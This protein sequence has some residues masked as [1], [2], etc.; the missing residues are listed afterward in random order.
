VQPATADY[1]PPVYRRRP[2]HVL[3]TLPAIIND[4]H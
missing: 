4:I 3:Q 2:I 1:A